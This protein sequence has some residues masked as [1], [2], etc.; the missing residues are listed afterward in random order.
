MLLS[1]LQEEAVIG[2]DWWKDWFWEK[3]NELLM[4]NGSGALEEKSCRDMRVRDSFLPQEAQ[5]P[6]EC[7]PEC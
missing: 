7:S 2:E 5:S 6:K 3:G 4:G 1:A